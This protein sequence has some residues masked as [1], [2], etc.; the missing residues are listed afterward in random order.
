MPEP[1]RVFIDT[2]YVPAPCTTTVP[3]GGDLQAV[4]NAAAQGDT[5]CLANDAAFTGNFILPYHPT[6]T[7]WITIR[8][9]DMSGIPNQNTRISPANASVMPKINTATVDTALKTASKAHHYRFVGIEIASIVSVPASSS[10]QLQFGIIALGENG[11][12]LDQLPTNFTFDRCYIH[13]DPVANN[14]RGIFMNAASVAVVDSYISEIHQN[15]GDDQALA[16]VSSPGPFKIVNNFLEAGTNNLIFGGGPSATAALNPS[17]IEIRRN[18]FFKPRSWSSTDPSYAGMKWNIKNHLELK[19]AQRVVIEGN[20]FEN[21]WPAAQD[22]S[23]V[24]TVRTSTAL[25]PWSAV[26]DVMIQNNWFKNVSGVLNASGYDDCG[27]SV[28]TGPP[29]RPGPAEA[30]GTQARVLFRNNIAQMR[31]VPAGVYEGV[32]PMG[33]SYTTDC[34]IDHNTLVGDNQYMFLAIGGKRVPTNNFTLTNNLSMLGSGGIVGDSTGGADAINRYA[35]GATVL[36][37]VLQGSGSQSNFGPVSAIKIVAAIGDIGY[38]SPPDDLHLATGSPHKNAGTDGKDIGADVDAVLAATLRVVQGN[39]PPPSNVPPPAISPTG[40]VNLTPPQSVTV[41]CPATNAQA[42]Y[43]TDGSE[44]NKASTAYSQTLTFNDYTILKAACFTPDGGSS[45]VTSAVFV[46]T[47]PVGTVATPYFGPP[48]GIF[49]LPLSLTLQS[50]TPDAYIY[51]TLD[52]TDPSTSSPLYQGSLTLTG[53]TTVKAKAVKLG[54]VDSNTARVIFTKVVRAFLPAPDL[55]RLPRYVPVD[56]SLAFDYSAGSGATG[57]EW[58][59][60]QGNPSTN[61][62]GSLGLFAAGGIA[63]KYS[64]QSPQFSFAGRNLPVGTYTLKVTVLDANG[65]SSPAASAIITLVSADFSQTRVYPNPWRK[66]KHAT[67]NVTFDRLPLGSTV[68]IFTVSGHFVNTLTPTVDTATW[69]LTN[70]QGDKVASGIYI[71]LI[72]T[73]DSGSSGNGQRIR[74]KLGVIR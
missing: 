40:G 72:T 69:D 49:S 12:G 54:L 28:L 19:T 57:F 7:G 47:P 31:P 24:L 32:F 51:Y 37:N 21:M 41:T 39:P 22:Q 17:D 68:K 33:V 6:G 46:F 42:R 48:G 52:G 13:G 53:T 34:T 29:C 74:G 3:N 9:A 61:G 10:N 66:D 27:N 67:L 56:G 45:S 64:S 65:A 25:S 55:S 35:P 71:Y 2:T 11:E 30:P 70:D 18:H 23:L 73:G 5:I 20:V 15:Q 26:I 58:S 50:T 16:A 63:G 62:Y 60:T 4:L 14:K 43:T 59:L 8:P 38:V 36:A 44:P 1:P